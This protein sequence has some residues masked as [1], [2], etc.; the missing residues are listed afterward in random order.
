MEDVYAE[1]RKGGDRGTEV[2]L[3]AA[4]QFYHKTGSA[5]LASFV[6]E[7]FDQLPKAE[8]LSFVCSGLEAMFK[9]TQN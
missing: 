5:G 4:R 6:H 1:I 7:A 2:F 9:S 3:R 8:Q